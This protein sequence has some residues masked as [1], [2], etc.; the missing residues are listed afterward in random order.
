MKKLSLFV[1]ALLMFLAFA[2]ASESDFLFDKVNSVRDT[3]LVYSNDL[4]VQAQRY[5]DDL[6]ENGEFNTDYW[7]NYT[8]K[9]TPPYGVNLS[10]D[11]RSDNKMFKAFLKDSKTRANVYNE[12][13]VE[14]GIARN[15]E[16]N[17]FVQFFD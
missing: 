1:V 9:M 3:D 17:I 2:G 7:Q 13:Y 12:A 15:D 14:T 10:K 16:C 8:G 4:E 5:A 11:F 6:C